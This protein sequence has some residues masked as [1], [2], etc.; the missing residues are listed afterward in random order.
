[1]YAPVV[2]E[3]LYFHRCLSVHRGGGVDRPQ[4]R[5]PAVNPHLEVP[6]QTDTLPSQILAKQRATTADVKHHT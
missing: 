4:G 3:R 5:C 1:M 6:P 2:A